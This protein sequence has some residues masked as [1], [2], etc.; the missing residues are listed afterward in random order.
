MSPRK[1]KK[2]KEREKEAHKKVLARREALR[3]PKI[4]E[5][6]LRKKMKRIGKLQKD[7]DGLSQWADDVLLKMNDKTL[8]Q[9]ERNAQ[10]L[11]ALE[12]EH[13]ADREKKQKLNLD[14]ESKGLF[15]LQ[16]KL[17]YL[18][19]ELVE[20]QKSAGFDSFEEAEL[21][22]ATKPRKEV[23]EVTVLKASDCETTEVSPSEV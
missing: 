22:K 3:A 8:S 9:L 18:H 11:K 17:S 5:N 23:A 7:M 12:A 16:D 14:L 13:E 4:E 15:G 20:Q 1:L 6:K 19:N 10:I 21:V 2:K